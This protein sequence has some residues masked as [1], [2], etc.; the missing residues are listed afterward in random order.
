MDMTSNNEKDMTSNNEIDMTSN[1]TNVRPKV[2]KFAALAATQQK[3]QNPMHCTEVEDAPMVTVSEYVRSNKD[4][5]KSDKKLLPLA[6]TI[7]HPEIPLF[8]SGP[9][10]RDKF[11]SMAAA[12]SS[13]S[14][15]DAGDNPQS[16]RP[17]VDKFAAIQLQ[18]QTDDLKHIRERTVE[19]S[20]QRDGILSDCDTAEDMIVK[21][22]RFVEQTATVYSDDTRWQLE[23]PSIKSSREDFA[24]VLG[25]YQEAL[26]EVHGLLSKH[27][28]HVKA[29]KSK[30]SE[31]VDTNSIYI[32]R[33]EQRLADTKL[34]LMQDFMDAAKGRTILP[35]PELTVSVDVGNNK[36][37]RDS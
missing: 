37:K 32:Q 28:P 30:E 34:E 26:V 36:R 29:Y 33:V 8:G 7:S 1:G 20:K 14:F 17:V 24:N 27:A 21:L 13:A 11:A 3:Q 22:L 4:D 35:L 16:R 12:L 25:G 19:L 23:T 5:D 31:Q 6:D 9:A 18:K 2:D 10:R 15:D